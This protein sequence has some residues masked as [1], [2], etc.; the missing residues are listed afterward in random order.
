MTENG[1][2]TPIDTVLGDLTRL[3]EQLTWVEALDILVVA[4][5]FYALL[6]I[7]RGTQA[8]NLLRG[9]IVLV[10]LVVVF[11]GLFQ[12]RAVSWLLR[13]TL[14]ALLLAIPVIMLYELSILG[15]RLIQKRSGDE[16]ES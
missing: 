7:V 16:T 3:L 11:S 15:A 1:G 9:V 4:L 8:V 10:I 5:M 6:V 12:L 14:P 13:A 2:I